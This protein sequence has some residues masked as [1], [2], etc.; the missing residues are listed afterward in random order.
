[1]LAAIPLVVPQSLGPLVAFRACT[2]ARLRLPVGAG[3]GDR[4]LPLVSAGLLFEQL[5][6]E[7]GEEAVGLSIGAASRFEGTPLGAH[8]AGSLTIGAALAAAAQASARY[9]GGQQLRVTQHGDDVWLQRRHSDALRRG[10]RQA[11]DFALQMLID[12]LRRGA[13]PRW[14]PTDLQLEGPAPGHAEELAA[15]AVRSTRFGATADCLVFPASVLTLPLP[16]APRP[17]GTSCPPLPDLDFVDSIRQTVRYLLEVGELNLPNVAEAAGTGA[18]SL[19]RRLAVSGLS[20]AR[21]ADE[22]RFQVASR[23]LRDPTIRIIDV[24]VA[25]GYTDAANFTRAFRRW[26]GVPPLT[27]RCAALQL[28]AAAS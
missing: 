2:H 25:L 24:S 26:A 15:L 19:Q 7:L 10:R 23:L 4:P 11:S 22:V 18:R 12:V 8:V 28:D 5:A 16:P 13:G 27:F 3:T 14:R 1:M 6:V 17:A 20:F 21:L 9:C